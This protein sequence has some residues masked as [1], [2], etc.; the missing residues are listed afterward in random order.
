MHIVGLCSLNA[1]TAGEVS[2]IVPI[3]QLGRKLV[4]E[5]KALVQGHPVST[6]D[7]HPDTLAPEPKVIVSV[8]VISNTT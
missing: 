7:L 4:M 3:T 1:H 6:V 2:S 8:T 5:D